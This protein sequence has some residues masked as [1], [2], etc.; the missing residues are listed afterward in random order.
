MKYQNMSDCHNHSNMSPDGL[1]TPKVMIKRAEE[2]NLKYYTMTDHCECDL[3]N[4]K[5]LDKTFCER[6]KIAKEKMAEIKSTYNGNLEFLSGLEMGQPTQ[7]LSITEEVL[8]YPYDFVLGSL[9]NLATYK[10][11]RFWDIKGYDIDYAIKTYFTE[12]Y[13]IVQWGKFDAVG[14]LTY[15]MRY[16]QGDLGIK[17]DYSKYMDITKDVMKLVID[18][19][20]AIEI[21]TSGIRQKLGLS[22]PHKEV[23]KAYYDLGGRLVTLGSDAHKAE[24]LGK[25]IEESLD[26]MKEIGFTHFTV[27]KN[28]KPIQIEIK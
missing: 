22:M 26:L 20:M 8:D 16:V 17:V 18:K 3:Y 23:L 13:E 2:L 11:F 12:L 6:V 15:P 9:H 21:N 4:T 24:D 27:Y 5:P 1:D 10:E 28:R 7:N 14:H 19:N 25:G